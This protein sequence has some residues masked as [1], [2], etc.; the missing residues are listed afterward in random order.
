MNILRIRNNCPLL[1]IYDEVG[2][3]VS[4]NPTFF[5]PRLMIWTSGESDSDN[6]LVHSAEHFILSI[7]NKVFLYDETNC[8]E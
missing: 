7:E 4:L 6:S 8:S 5:A 3:E 1:T 2:S